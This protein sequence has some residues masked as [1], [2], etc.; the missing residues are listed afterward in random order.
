M[1]EQK[2][3]TLNC[4]SCGAQLKVDDFQET[5]TCEYCDTTFS[6]AELLNESDELRIEK[7]KN[8]AYV[9]V[10]KGKREVESEYLKHKIEQEKVKE[11]EDAIKKFKKSKLG[12]ALIIWTV[13]SAF[14]CLVSFGNGDI[15]G[16]LIAVAM[17]ALSV[18]SW[19]MGAQIVNEKKKGLHVICAIVAFALIIPYFKILNKP[20][21][22][23]KEDIVWSELQLGN[24]LPEPD[25]TLGEVGTDLDTALIVTLYEFDESDYKKYVAECQNIG[26]TIEPE[27]SPTT[28]VAYNDEGYQVR[29]VKGDVEFWIH[30]DAPEKM[31]AF[32][33]PKYGLAVMLPSPK[34]SIGRIVYDN[35][36]SFN[37]HVGNMSVDD[38]NGY[39]K[40]C[41]DKG[42]KLNHS[43]S[44]TY[45]TAENSNGQEITLR[46]LGFNRVEISI[47]S[48]YSI[49]YFDAES[50][51]Y[52]LNND[53]E[54][55]GNVVKFEL[56]DYKPD[57]AFGVN[58]W[59]GEHL[60]FIS[61]TECDV[62]QGDIIICQITEEPYK[63][64]GSWIIDC[65]ILSIEKQ[66]ENTTLNSTAEATT[67]NTTE[68]L[69]E[70]TTTVTTKKPTEHTT[71]A[72]TKKSITTTKKQPITT[73]TEKPRAVY[74]ST[75]DYETAKKGNTGVYSYKN[76]G[77]TYDI[78]WIIDFNEGYVYWFTDGN[79]E[80]SCDKVK[81][82]S[83]DLNDRVTVTWHDGGDQWS[84]YLHFKY[85]NNPS[86]LIVNDH[87][88]F[89]AEFTTT[90]LESALKVRD[91]KT[92]M[93]Y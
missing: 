79:G 68:K 24:I 22:K 45:Y 62:K 39:I 35:S 29:L 67:E 8:R 89:P 49:D 75:N 25:S 84:W 6:V 34:S 80:T 83:G 56:N 63:F 50:F 90:D 17:V 21:E 70:S 26:F 3:Q 7:N 88:G 10:E 14:F 71:T 20:T 32:E 54:V 16:S 82:D 64:L 66:A 42:F 1:D 30:L 43:K 76:T 77:G 5:V 38:F 46:Y 12:I 44:E 87:N 13:I 36:E 53:E 58:L 41:Q 19:L 78:Y 60:N 18:L 57:S 27:K 59:A 61:E 23:P 85:V 47:K 74:Y 86:T 52:D 9:E 48:S 31:K 55:D 15:F 4:S 72:T 37:V 81:I 51:E 92:I 33:W 69:K 28:Y 2:V 73:V 40:D 65:N 91:T 93:K 11:K